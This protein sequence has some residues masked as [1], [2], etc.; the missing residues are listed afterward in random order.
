MATSG[1]DYVVP[2]NILQDAFGSGSYIGNLG[3][4]CKKELQIEKTTHLPLRFRLGS[5]AQNNHLEGKPG[6]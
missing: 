3:Y 4:F 6:W 5:L 1:Y 2:A